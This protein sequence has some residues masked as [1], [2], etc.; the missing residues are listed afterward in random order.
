MHHPTVSQSVIQLFITKCLNF[1]KKNKNVLCMS[2]NTTFL[3]FITFCTQLTMEAQQC[4]CNREKL[5]DMIGQN[6]KAFTQMK[7]QHEKFTMEIKVSAISQDRNV[8]DH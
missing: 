3:S 1:S 2:L 4:R 5:E 7:H 6:E 8:V